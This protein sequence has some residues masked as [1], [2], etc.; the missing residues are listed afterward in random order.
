MHTNVECYKEIFIKKDK[1]SIYEEV[2]RKIKEKKWND[3]LYEI[4]STR[5]NNILINYNYFK[6]FVTTE[7]YDTII[8]LITINVDKVLETYNNYNIYLNLQM[9]SISEIEKHKKF[10]YHIS[11]YMMERYQNKYLNKCYIY[12]VPF[13]GTHFVNIIRL[14]NSKETMEKI[15]LVK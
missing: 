9:L 1:N 13:A 15:E 3:I 5:E 4:C 6:Y 2:S 8:H 11:Q 14:F 7:T 12:N 10:F